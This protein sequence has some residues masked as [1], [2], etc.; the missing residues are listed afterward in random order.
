MERLEREKEAKDSLAQAN[1]RQCELLC[2]KVSTLATE[3]EEVKTAAQGK[4]RLLEAKE[5]ENFKLA[6]VLQD[7][8]HKFE[9]QVHHFLSA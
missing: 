1:S 3:L 5:H 8:R 4:Q 6:N 2:K 7:L 9:I